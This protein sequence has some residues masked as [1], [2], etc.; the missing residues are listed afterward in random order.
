ME[1]LRQRL[2]DWLPD[3]QEPGR[4]LDEPAFPP[5]AFA[6]MDRPSIQE[7]DNVLKKYGEFAGLGIDGLHP[8][9]VRYLPPVLQEGFIDVL[10]QFERD[11]VRPPSLANVRITRPKED[12][13]ART[14]G[15][16]PPLGEYGRACGDQ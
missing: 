2:E 9:A 11:P 12:G 7:L 8:Q 3:W 6:C 1:T 4:V 10:M 14:I 15:L 13:T 5:E 16:P